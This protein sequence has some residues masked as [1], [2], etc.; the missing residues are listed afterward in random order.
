MFED[1]LLH[2]LG[3]PSTTGAGGT[4]WRPAP[5]KRTLTAQLAPKR[6]RA[7]TVAD[8]GAIAAAGTV[9]ASSSLPHLDQLQA[10][11]GHHDLSDVRAQIGGDGARAADALGAHAYA[12]GDAVAF[13]EAPD[14][15][16]AA[17]EAAHVVQQRGGVRLDGGVGAVGDVYERH[18]DEVAAAV[19][20]G[21]SVEALLDPFAHR[22][23]AGGPAVQRDARDAAEIQATLD[24]LEALM[25]DEPDIIE[26]EPHPVEGDGADP[27][28]MSSRPPPPVLF[29]AP[30][31]DDAHITAAE[32]GDYTGSISAARGGESTELREPA[33]LRLDRE[34]TEAV[35]RMTA[36]PLAAVIGPPEA[37]PAP[38][39]PAPGF[40]PTAGSGNVGTAYQGAPGASLQNASANVGV[41]GHVTAEFEV[42][43]GGPALGVDV[44]LAAGSGS[45]TARAGDEDGTHAGV[46]LE[47][48]DGHL[49]SADVDAQVGDDSG[50]NATASTHID[51]RHGV[52]NLSVGVQSGRMGS[53]RGRVGGRFV[54]QATFGTP[55]LRDGS[56]VVRATFSIIAEITGS[57]R[58]RLISGTAAIGGDFTQTT[59]RRFSTR[60][61]AQQW[62]DSVRVEVDDMAAQLFAG[63]LSVEAARDLP[64][65]TEVEATRGGHVEA[66]ATLAPVTLRARLAYSS[67]LIYRPIDA[68]TYRVGLRSEWTASGT[69]GG[70]TPIAGG[71]GTL[72]Y[73]SRT[74]RVV[75]F[76]LATMPGCVAL[77]RALRTGELPTGTG[78]GW[79]TVE[80]S[81]G[82][83]RATQ[84]DL[85]AVGGTGRLRSETAVDRVTGADGEVDVR[86]RGTSTLTGTD[87]PWA[88]I[89]GADSDAGDERTA[90]ELNDRGTTMTSRLR[91]AD[92]ASAQRALA[93][94]TGTE[95]SLAGDDAREPGGRWQVQVRLDE[96]A[97]RRVWAALRR[98]SSGRY[99]HLLG[100]R[101]N[102]VRPLQTAAVH[103]RDAE[104]LRPAIAR[105]VAEGG[106][107]ADQFLRALA[108]GTADYDL[109]LE[110]SPLFQGAA[111]RARFAATLDE[112]GLRFSS[113]VDDPTLEAD[114][115]ARVR[116]QQARVEAITSGRFPLPP[117]VQRHE[118]DLQRPLLDRARALLGEVEAARRHRAT[119][120][121]RGRSAEE[122]AG[123]ARGELM[124]SEATATAGATLAAQS[125][126]ELAALR[127]DVARMLDARARVVRVKAQVQAEARAHFTR[128]E[129]TG[130]PPHDSIVGPFGIGGELYASAH[131]HTVAAE[132]DLTAARPRYAEYEELR[133][134]VPDGGVLDDQTRT[135]VAMIRQHAWSLVTTYERAL[136]ELE[137]ARQCYL[138][139]RRA[140]PDP[141]FWHRSYPLPT[142]P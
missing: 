81:T 83:T 75:E 8:P 130:I 7:A 12:F 31:P 14:L 24:R 140:H 105:F 98:P 73:R 17:H 87:A 22:G 18:A 50:A 39:P 67:T 110:G 13:A 28:S 53:Y 123:E 33:D 64:P 2:G 45:A 66:G 138:E 49:A 25:R 29:R 57:G 131:A 20:R 139:I 99:A 86:A 93:A 103:A 133:S 43:G 71:T 1:D 19:V 47:V 92:G 40:R 129:N 101:A 126:A 70:T 82:S 89:L 65:G 84:A 51:R 15:R 122:L 77:D 124:S 120:A 106:E 56:Y 78:A 6:G 44:D 27:S 91:D 16:L 52:T 42:P 38:P 136:T 11:F 74:G 108:G 55:E 107:A 125:R 37:T 48:E 117:A 85:S 119:T 54:Y 21:E 3:A 96:A 10:A 9:G 90:I 26:A 116:D 68:V 62:I 58:T 97:M 4:R 80:L 63:R 127:G 137:Q 112:L 113:D 134:E 69:A 115:R 61:A 41:N 72:E 30:D 141:R 76:D 79:R 121:A 118:L 5:G 95:T 135:V 88:T 114:V 60:D 32:T 34:D 23:A 35:E 111:G 46:S 104:A 102:L 59:D 142:A 128:S 36:S 100:T 94:S 132:R 109:L